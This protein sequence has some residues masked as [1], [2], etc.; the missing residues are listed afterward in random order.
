MSGLKYAA[1]GEHY[2]DNLGRG[3]LSGL[4]KLLGILLIYANWH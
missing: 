4:S 3:P 1:C 2:S